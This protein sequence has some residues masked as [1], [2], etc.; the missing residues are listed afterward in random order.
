MLELTGLSCVRGTRRLFSNVNAVVRSGQLLRLQGANGAGK[1]SLL[2]TLCGL[3]SP[4]Q[5]EVRW[6]GRPLADDRDAF[7]RELIYLGHAAALKD[8]LSAF[9]NLDAASVLG[10]QRPSASQLTSA[11]AAAG[12]RHREH[13]S[14]RSLSQGQRRRVSLA[15]LVLAPSPR[16]WVLDEPFN[17]LD[18]AATD[19]LLS[20]VTGQL[21]AGGIVVLTSHQPVAIDASLAQVTL[22][23]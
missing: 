22:T 16:L 14:A 19:W 13:L 1:T 21:R 18:T 10:G 17:A 6:R 5:G 12:L 11:L 8:D 23:L 4:D 9:E 15:R 7:H 2:R 20:V 3:S